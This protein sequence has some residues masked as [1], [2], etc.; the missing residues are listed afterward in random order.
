MNT[1]SW[2]SSTTAASRA[3]SASVVTQPSPW[4]TTG[5]VSTGVG[6]GVGAGTGVAVGVGRGV[7]TTVGTGV[8]VGMAVGWTAADGSTAT[9]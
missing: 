9:A 6:V 7:G 3:T 1:S 8:G 4:M 5:V 2:I